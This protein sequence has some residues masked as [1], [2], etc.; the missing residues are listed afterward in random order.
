[1]QAV[2][3]RLPCRI[4]LSKRPKFRLLSPNVKGQGATRVAHNDVT[5]VS[6]VITASQRNHKTCIDLV[7][8]DCGR[9]RDNA[10]RRAT[11]T[12]YCAHNTDPA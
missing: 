8:T 10:Q 9:G 5:R 2:A 4:G 6:V 3:I 11:R 12:R 7:L 1:V